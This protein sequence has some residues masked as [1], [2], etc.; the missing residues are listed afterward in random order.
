MDYWINTKSKMNVFKRDGLT[1]EIEAYLIAAKGVDP[2]LLASNLKISIN[3]IM[4]WQRELGL[5][6]LSSNPGQRY[7]INMRGHKSKER[8]RGRGV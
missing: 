3:K 1:A 2:H 4:R 5:R 6:E 8:V 7:H